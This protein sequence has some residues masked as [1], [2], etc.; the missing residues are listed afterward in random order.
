MIYYLKIYKLNSWN[1]FGTILYIQIVT[2]QSISPD[3][4]LVP[5]TGLQSH[6]TAGCRVHPATLAV[7][8]GSCPNQGLTIEVD[9]AGVSIIVV[10]LEL[11]TVTQSPCSRHRHS[12]DT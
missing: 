7:G 6:V 1:V 9:V 3:L 5:G 11:Q 4:D 8:P 10:H 2:T 12:K